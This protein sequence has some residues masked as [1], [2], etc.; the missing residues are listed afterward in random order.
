MLQFN[1]MPEKKKPIV[2][3]V[4]DEIMLSK[5]I[6][7]L[8]ESLNLYQA[9]CAYN[10]EEALEKVHKHQHFFGYAQSDIACIL[11]DVQMPKMNGLEFL[12]ILRQQE[13]LHT[14]NRFIP[15]VLLTA[16]EDR[17]KWWNAAHPQA[18]M[19]AEYLIKPFDRKDLEE[20][21]HRIVFEKDVQ[22]LIEITQEKKNVRWDEL[23]E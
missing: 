7:Q 11:L 17:D 16:Y 22:T 13:S 1:Q 19:A 23:Q 21:L 6:A 8:V 5:K 3:V 14:F 12:K 4:E 15:V 10:G 20:I 2:L 9:I 18:G